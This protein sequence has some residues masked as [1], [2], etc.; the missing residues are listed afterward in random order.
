M[1]TG[2]WQKVQIPLLERLALADLAERKGK[3]D[4][5]TLAEIIRDAVRRECAKAGGP[6]SIENQEVQDAG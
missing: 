4:E 1:T 2:G 5:Q 3:S 6:K